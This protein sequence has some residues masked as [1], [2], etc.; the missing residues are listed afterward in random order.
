MKKKPAALRTLPEKKNRND[1]LENVL[2]PIYDVASPVTQEKEKS[3]YEKS[4]LSPLS[5]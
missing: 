3:A 5:S 1:E 2:R 4:F